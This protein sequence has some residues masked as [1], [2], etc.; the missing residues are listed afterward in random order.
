MVAAT[1]VLA[2]LARFQRLAIYGFDVERH[3]FR[4]VGNTAAVIVV[5]GG[6]V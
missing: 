6:L 5:T 3:P 1:S 4:A 2:I